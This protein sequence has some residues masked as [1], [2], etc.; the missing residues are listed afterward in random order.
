MS[1]A[2]SKRAIDRDDRARAAAYRATI[3]RGCA[4]LRDRQRPDGSVLGCD[5]VW[6]YYSQPIALHAGGSGD[7]WGVANRCLD[8]VVA[9]YSDGQGRLS[10]ESLPLVGDLYPYPYLIR[11]AV[12][13]ERFDIAGRLADRL[14]ESQLECGGFAF[15]IGDD[16]IVDPAATSH[17]ALS[18]IAAGRL[19]EA[20]RAGDLIRR[21]HDAQPE[22]S[23]RYLT[24]W[25]AQADAPMDDYAGLTDMPWG[26]GSILRTE[27]PAGANAYWDVGFMIALMS[28]LFSL[29][30]DS[31]YLRVGRQMFDLFRDY[32]GFDTH[33]W[34]TPW[35]CAA[36]YQASGTRDALDVAIKM[37]DEIVS[38]QQPD[39]GFFLGDQS[40]Y[41]S[42]SERDWSYGFADYAEL[43]ENVPIL[44][45]TA[46][47]M[48][49]Y[50]GRVASV[51]PSGS[52]DA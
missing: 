46:S 44:L 26:E 22:P 19:E 50:L 28:A 20:I 11:G 23:R 7:N 10:I 4:F 47:Q 16:R 29:T 12:A 21:L 30:G 8:H 42:E 1:S 18:L 2:G 38:T 39:G 37:G 32:R 51:L 43:G 14:L 33:I 25:D 6:G 17:G 40:N 9:A 34:K 3:E 13:W 31:D 27:N 35:G 5:S 15:R 24:V 52:D 48:T 49:Y 36:L 45:D 41:V